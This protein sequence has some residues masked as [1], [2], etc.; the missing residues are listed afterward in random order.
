MP[1]DPGGEKCPADVIGNAVIVAQ[2][3]SGE[4]EDKSTTVRTRRLLRWGAEVASHRPTDSPRCSALI[5]RKRWST[6]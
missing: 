5:S 4:E 2:I 6:K 1:I 3:A